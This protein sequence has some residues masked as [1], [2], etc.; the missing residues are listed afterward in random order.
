MNEELLT[1]AEVAHLLKV[2]AT[3]VRRWIKQGILKAVDLPR[4][5][6]RHSYRVKNSEIDTLL[7]TPPALDGKRV[8]SLS[9]LKAD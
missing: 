9:Y 6:N 2:D 1:V 4:Q 5:R 7:N 3:T 8:V